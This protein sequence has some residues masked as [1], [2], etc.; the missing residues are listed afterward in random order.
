[1]ESIQGVE[2]EMKKQ[3]RDFESA[4]EFVRKLGLK[5]QKEWSD[6]CKSCNKP[7]DIPAGP[8]RNY[9]NTGW[10]TLSDFLGNGNTASQNRTYREFTKARKFVRSLKLKNQK[11]WYTY[12]KSENR[13]LDIP[14]APHTVY[15]KEWKGYS[16]WMGLDTVASQNK[17]FRSFESAKKYISSLHLKNRTEFRLFLKST[18][19]PDDIPAAPERVYKKEW[20]GMG[21]F[22][23][24]G[25]EA[26]RYRN[27]LS[28]DDAKIFLKKL[29]IKS[30]KEF[31]KLSKT[32][33]IPK[34]IPRSPGTAYKKEWKGWGDFLGNG[35]VK[36]GDIQY[37]SFKEA[38]LFVQ[39]LGLKTYSD[40]EK[41]C[42]SGD[43][44]D[45]IPAAPWQVY[46][47]WKQ[48]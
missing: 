10:K 22:L 40:W 41:Y 19:K 46:K 26:N 7:D 23:G 44:P 2:K 13:P 30:S 11:E 14:S 24:N 43:K 16:D 38:K 21:D 47:E 25:N 42:A 29:D 33:K 28:Y 12:T 34:N 9:K 8:W 31:H 48:K 39:K 6:Y 3:F 20:K 32:I 35:N 45:D 37:R 36:S 27:F 18:K 17:E 15:K 5:T 1:M 4:R